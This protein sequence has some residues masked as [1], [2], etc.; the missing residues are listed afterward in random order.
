MHEE[1]KIIGNS[2]HIKKLLEFI[3]KAA[4]TDAN[5]LLLGESGVGKELAAKIIHSHSKKNDNPIIKINCANLN[6]PENE[7]LKERIIGQIIKFAFDD[8]LDNTGL[9]YYT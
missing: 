3:K 9:P 5:V 7:K 2:Q 8:F 6:R 4:K 1:I